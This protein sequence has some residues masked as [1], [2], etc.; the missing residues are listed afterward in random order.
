[1]SSTMEQPA[2]EP[3]LDVDDVRRI[4][5]VS[6]ATIYSLVKDDKLTP[7]DIGVRKTRFRRSDIQA[8]IDG[9]ELE[10]GA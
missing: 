4:L 6:R 8:F 2:I 1:M 3:L 5:K 7:V 10:A 9:V